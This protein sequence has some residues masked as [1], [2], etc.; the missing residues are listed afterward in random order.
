MDIGVSQRALDYVRSRATG[1]MQAQCKIVRVTGPSFDQATGRATT[2]TRSTIY[3]GRC[4]VWEVVGGGTPML[5]GEEEVEVDNTQL[6]LPFDVNPVPKRY[7]QVEI[8]AHATDP[9]MVGKRFEINSGAM[10]GDLRAT[11]RFSIRRFSQ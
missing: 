6:S 3:Q 10:A 11:R 1:V 5:I 4:R 7:D 2:G 9:S 8:T